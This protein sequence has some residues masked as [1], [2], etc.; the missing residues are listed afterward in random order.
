MIRVLPLLLLAGACASASE[1][2]GSA[3]ACGART[4]NVAADTG[5]GE[6]IAGESVDDLRQHC[7]IIRDSTQ[8]WEEG[9][10]AR[11]LSVM[12]GTDTVTAVVDSNR[13]DQVFIAD[14]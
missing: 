5:V 2:S 8:A 3:L 1:R 7:R 6:V 9:L 11:I 4:P 13:V 14:S 10:D 12:V